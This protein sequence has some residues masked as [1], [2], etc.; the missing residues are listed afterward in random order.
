VRG[1]AAVG[2]ALVSRV[3]TAVGVDKFPQA[4]VLEVDGAV[5][6]VVLQT[7][8]SL[9]TDTDAVALLDVRD[10]GTDTDGFSDDFVPDDAGCGGDCQPMF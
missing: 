1:I 10:V 8:S 7:R 9:G 2:F 5:W 4:V 6:A 3:D